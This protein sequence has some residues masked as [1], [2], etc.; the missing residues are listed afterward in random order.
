[1]SFRPVFYDSPPELQNGQESGG[2]VD[3]TGALRVAIAGA[4][5]NIENVELDLDELNAALAPAGDPAPV[6][7]I[8][9]GVL[10][11]TGDIVNLSL[12]SAGQLPV[13]VTGIEDLATGANQ[14]LIID[15]LELIEA[16]TSL[17]QIVDSV[18]LSPTNDTTD[19]TPPLPGGRI[20]IRGSEDFHIQI[21]E[22]PT[23]SA[24]TSPPLTADTDY[25]FEVSDGDIV[26]TLLASES[27]GTVWVAT[28]DTIAIP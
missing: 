8:A 1:M 2:T 3:D 24:A 6:N 13:T 7:V 18:V 21:G 23:A 17:F 27:T 19:D 16:N 26:S 12:N 22:T 20:W 10:D 9:I 4:E 28:E 25:Y 15:T 11:D 5:I 14:G